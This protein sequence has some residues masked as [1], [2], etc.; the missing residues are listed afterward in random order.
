MW[1][2]EAYFP[3]L[4]GYYSLIPS[5]PRVKRIKR[6]TVLIVNLPIAELDYNKKTPHLSMSTVQRPNYAKIPLEVFLIQSRNDS[7]WSKWYFKSR[8]P[9]R[10]QGEFFS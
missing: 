3:K 10:R 2:C 8:C 5:K 1:K 4:P 6:E 7:R 9:L